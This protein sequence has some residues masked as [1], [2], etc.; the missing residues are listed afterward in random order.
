MA[1]AFEREEPV[2][3]AV[4]RIM[5]EQLSRAREQLTDPASPPEERVHDARKRFKET[6][7]LLRMVREPL[8]AQFA[9]ENVAFRDAGRDLAAVRDADAVLE[10]L[11]RLELSRWVRARVKRALE[12]N[13]VHAPLDELI[14]NTLQQLSVA[15]ARLAAWPSL[16]D[17]FDTLANGLR[18]TYRD[19]RRSMKT[20]RSAEELHEWRKHVKTHWYHA[21]LLRHIWPSVMKPYTSELDDLSHFLGDHHDLHVLAESAVRS[22][23][24][25]KAIAARQKELERDAANLGARIFAER[26]DAWLARMRKYWNAWRA[27]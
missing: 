13:R 8:G 19:G 10:A 22:P 12:M 6:R 24:L 23:S 2:Q 11:E 18:R 25:R 5:H 16:E 1:Y 17:S 3:A 7:A 20:A 26:P 14:A 21:Q 27:H 4:L 9:I 15:E